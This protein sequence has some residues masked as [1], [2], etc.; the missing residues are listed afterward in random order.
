MLPLL[1]ILKHIQPLPPKM[2]FWDHQLGSLVGRIS[3][4][5]LRSVDAGSAFYLQWITVHIKVGKPLICNRL[6]ELLVIITPQIG[7]SIDT[8]LYLN[9]GSQLI[10]SELGVRTRH[11]YFEK[12]SRR[13]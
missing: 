10:D 4:R 9:G 6:S 2:W 7:L 3:G 12:F 13:L 1:H 8:Y 11:R 5:H